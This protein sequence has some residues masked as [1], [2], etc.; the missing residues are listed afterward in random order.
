M[1]AW[2]E[3]MAAEGEEDAQGAQEAQ[4]AQEAGPAAGTA[5]KAPRQ[6]SGEAQKSGGRMPAI[7]EVS[8]EAYAILGPASMPVSQLLSMGRGA[9]GEQHG[10]AS[11]RERVCKYV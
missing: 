7:H 5:V 11:W 10:R 2:W 4:E 8:L 1:M 9:V 6:A 3:A